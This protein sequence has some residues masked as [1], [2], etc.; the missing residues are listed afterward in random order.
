M[1]C[2]LCPRFI[3]TIVTFLQA[4][5]YSRDYKRKYDFFRSKL[6][7]PVCVFCF[8]FDTVH[9]TYHDLL[10]L[11]LGWCSDNSCFNFDLKVG[12]TD[13]SLFTVFVMY[14]VGRTLGWFLQENVPNKV[15]IKVTRNNI[16]EDSFRCIMSIKRAD[17]LKTK[18]VGK[19]FVTC[20][21]ENAASLF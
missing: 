2:V 4:V 10:N 13:S 14:T 19:F 12:F 20:I 21:I 5:K 1:V 17:L 7:K 9:V 8:V 16:F 11:R 3:F 6:R 18:Y 15:D